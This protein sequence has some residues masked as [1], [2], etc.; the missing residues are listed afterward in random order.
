MKQD[1]VNIYWLFWAIELCF[2]NILYLFYYSAMLKH[3]VEYNHEGKFE[4]DQMKH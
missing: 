4:T 2:S 1:G 3:L